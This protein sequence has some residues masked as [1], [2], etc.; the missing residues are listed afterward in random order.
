MAEVYGVTDKGFVLKRYDEILEEIQNDVS[1]VV[2]F[3]VSQNPQSL[4][5]AALLVP[6]ADKI[7]SLWETAQDEYYAK[8]RHYWYCY[9][10]NYDYK[11]FTFY[12]FF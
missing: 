2:G 9:I 6:F 3:D 4:I 12:N 1:D 5:N 10:G 11:I 8:Y 7:A